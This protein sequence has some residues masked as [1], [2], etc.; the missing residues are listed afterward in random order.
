M[1]RQLLL[2][3]CWK[4][5]ILKKKMKHQDSLHLSSSLG[6]SK[7][8]SMQSIK[9]V[10]V[11][12]QTAMYS[13]RKD[14]SYADTRVSLYK[15]MKMKSSQSLPPRPRLNAASSHTCLLPSLSLVEV[16]RKVC[17][18]H[19]SREQRLDYWRREKFVRACLVQGCVVGFL[20]NA[21]LCQFDHSYSTSFKNS[22]VSYLTDTL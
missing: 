3:W 19:I 21:S 6:E 14:E 22:F 15:S 4:V 11:F 2:I 9:D 13:G 7:E 16:C 12:V 10:M 5:K 18:I 8:L 1:L 17:S 20:I